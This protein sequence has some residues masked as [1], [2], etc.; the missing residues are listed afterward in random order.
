MAA[1]RILK[2][3]IRLAGGGAVLLGLARWAGYLV[4]WLP[5]H[6]AFGIALVLTLVTVAILAWRAGR[7]PRLAALV[8]VWALL[9]LWLGYTQQRLLPGSQHW[10]IQVTHLAVGGIAMALGTRLALSLEAR[11]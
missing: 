6:M 7:Q 8:A 3:V 1:A 11:A 9:V 4:S 10:I 2:L 5:V